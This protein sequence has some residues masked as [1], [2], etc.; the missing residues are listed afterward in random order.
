M[1]FDFFNDLMWLSERIE[2]ICY[3]F[4]WYNLLLLFLS[5]QEILSMIRHDLDLSDDVHNT[6]NQHNQRQTHNFHQF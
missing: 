3:L 5:N 1:F 2:N 4:S 6:V